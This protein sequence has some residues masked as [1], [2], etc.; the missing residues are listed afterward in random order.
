[1]TLLSSPR[2]ALAGLALALLALLAAGAVFHTQREDSQRIELDASRRLA[3]LTT[4]LGRTQRELADTTARLKQ[5]ES[6]VTDLD[7]KLAEREGDRAAIADMYRELSRSVDERL[8]T[9]VEQIL[10][11]GQQ[12]LQ[13]S[14]NVAGAI[15]ALEAADQRLQRA[16]KLNSGRLRRAITQDLDRLRALPTV[17]VAGIAIK[18]DTLAASIDGLPAALGAGPEPATIRPAGTAPAPS[19]ETAAAWP[20]RLWAD[21]RHE[22]SQIIRVRDALPNEVQLLAPKDIQWVRQTLKLRLLSARFHLLA[23][24]EANY[25]ADLAAA[26]DLTSRYFDVRAKATI[27]LQAGIKTL[28]ASPITIGVPDLNGAMSELRAARLP[29]ERGAR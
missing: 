20:A 16:E 19:G 8:L 15:A 27:V 21:F 4:D 10:V 7:G 11:L 29:R 24:D 26:R 23:R 12:Q 25:R 28:A 22:L 5:T 1:M 2:I 18:L 14:G 13:L 9:E 17:D 6:R 3:Q